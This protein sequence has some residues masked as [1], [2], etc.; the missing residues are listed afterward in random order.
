[1]TNIESNRPTGSPGRIDGVLSPWAWFGPQAGFTLWMLTGM[2]EFGAESPRAAFAWAACFLVANGF[3]WWLWR[4]QNRGRLRYPRAAQL[5]VLIS[6]TLGLIAIATSPGAPPV[7]YYG[8][9]LIGG[10]VMV[11]MFEI[12][13]RLARR[14]VVD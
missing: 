4:R 1:M 13:D 2:L 12:W 5:L 9:L 11:G 6:M 10:L 3:G 14:R 8:A 7:T